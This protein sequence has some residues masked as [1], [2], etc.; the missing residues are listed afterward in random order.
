[1]ARLTLNDAVRVNPLAVGAHASQPASI[2]APPKAPRRRTAATAPRARRQ[3]NSAAARANETAPDPSATFAAVS[4][5]S[6]QSRQTALRLDADLVTRLAE[7]TQA[8]G[9]TVN[10]T[11]LTVAVLSRHVPSASAAAL[12]LLVDHAAARLRAGS[13]PA[14]EVNIRI[15]D[16]LRAR[17]DELV[18]EAKR[19]FPAASRSA[20]VSAI[21]ARHLPTDP[22]VAADVVLE[23]RL[24]QLPQR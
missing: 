17:L 23:L 16:P 13:R 22:A 2:A 4:L 10:L 14:R 7:L 12:E 9:A 3:P 20:L 6:A 11:A 15:P 24:A 5:G 19:E 8:G 21:L 1:M 18:R